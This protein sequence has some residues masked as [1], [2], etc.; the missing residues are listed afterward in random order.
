[1]TLERVLLRVLPLLLLALMVRQWV[2]MP[3][4]I[5]GDSML[6]T[7]RDGQLAGVNKLAYLFGPPRRWDIVAVWTGRDLMVKRIVGLPGE[8]VA[9]RGGTLYVNGSPLP[10][11]Y[12]VK[13]DWNVATGKLDSNS[14]LAVG[15]NRSQ[16]AA[17]LVGRGRILG[18][19]SL[20][21]WRWR[22]PPIRNH[23]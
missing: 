2:W 23:Q 8:E 9:A 20:L 16:T 18:R 19:L 4:L 5:R 12:A 6:P 13:R 14:F 1:L 22:A 7:L 15:D 21:R 17:V 10:E 11:P 3:L